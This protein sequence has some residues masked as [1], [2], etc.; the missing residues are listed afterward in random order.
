MSDK[1]IEL[2]K[3][4]V[5]TNLYPT[6]W[7]P[8]RAT[9]NRQQF[10]HLSPYAKLYYLVP[11][12]WLDWFKHRKSIK[13]TSTLNYV[14]Y[15]YLPKFGR[16]FSAWLMYFSVRLLAW[17]W[18]RE[19]QA[20][21]IIGC[22]A[23]PDAC[24]AQK[25]ASRLDMDFYMKV[26]GSDIHLHLKNRSRKAQIVNAANQAKGLLSVSQDL[27]KHMSNAGISNRNVKVIYNGV[28]V[29]LF[30]KRESTNVISFLFIGNLK[31]DKGVFELLE[32]FKVLSDSHPNMKLSYVGGGP[33]KSTLA[34][35]IKTLGLESQVELMGVVEHEKLPNLL[36]Q[37]TALCLPSYHEGVP[38]VVLEAMA[39]GLPCLATNVGGIPEVL[40]SSCGVLIEAQSVSAVTEGLR[41]VLDTNWDSDH[42]RAHAEQFSWHDNAI[43]LASLLSLR[44]SSQPANPEATS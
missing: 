24:A 3:V 38:N 20:K 5:F 40:P 14:P 30:T 18:L 33:E 19:S 6:P 23:Y 32:G 22:W 7:Q 8:T 16:R 26:H 35:R 39:S 15:F 43:G 27:A 37:S 41:L 42:I 11:V 28:N 4:V 9:F 1:Q 29:S 12:P 2:E 34:A 31:K 44:Q 36:S 25:V 17:S 21:K 10:S 13:N